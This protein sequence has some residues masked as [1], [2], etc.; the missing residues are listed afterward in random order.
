MSNDEKDL[1]ELLRQQ[2][3]MKGLTLGQLSQMSRVSPSYLG[4]IERGERSPSA[5]VLRRLAE[6]LGFGEVDLLTFAGY[7]APERWS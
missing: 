6:P 3:A 4:R 1:G 7:P 2:R 5:R